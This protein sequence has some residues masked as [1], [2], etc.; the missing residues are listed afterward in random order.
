MK[1]NLAK[2]ELWSSGAPRFNCP[3]VVGLGVGCASFIPLSVCGERPIRI[4]A[5][6]VPDGLELDEV[7][8]VFKGSVRT[9]L[10]Q[11]VRVKA[12]N[13]HGVDE[14]V[15]LM[16][17]T[18]GLLLTPPLGW[19]PWNLWMEN[20]DESK[21]KLAASTIVDT[22]LAAYGYNYINIDDGW[23]GER[24]GPYNAIQGNEN[25][26]DMGDLVSYIH[27]LGLRAGIYST[28]WVVSYAGFPGGSEASSP[29]SSGFRESG[30][31]VGM[32][33]F[34]EEDARQWAEWGID[35]MKY[36][37]YPTDIASVR[38][39]ADALASC[40]RD[41]AL[42][43]SN[44]TPFSLVG[45]ISGI[46]NMWRTTGDIRDRFDCL[47]HIIEQQDK[48]TG[49]AKPG[50]WNDP[51]MM[52]IGNLSSDERFSGGNL[53]EDE[54][55]MQMTIWILLAAPLI[56][57]CDLGTLGDFHFRLLCNEEALKIH[58]DRNGQQGYRLRGSYTFSREVQS[59]KDI[60]E[61]FE[62]LNVNE[63]HVYVR[64]L[65]DGSVAI[66]LINRGNE[67]C[68]ITLYWHELKIDGKRRIR[69]VWARNDLGSF[70]GS[71]S[72][73][74]PAHGAQLLRMYI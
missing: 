45:E 33:T 35:F 49:Y 50:H 5:E 36:D 54:Q 13:K 4:I 63:G 52:I 18:R 66:G 9:P 60:G 55:I 43:L 23:Q 69:D 51:D 64:E 58:R 10:R 21:I 24:S 15:M 57:G 25:F 14:I 12:S 71:F 22:G 40:G 11:E 6:G 32:P 41:I 1:T 48:W 42:S 2:V 56:L 30:H 26:P 28:P 29:V 65:S 34:E 47:L 20:I 74:V 7:A 39:I 59:P 53:S 19:N 62:Y 70:D 73:G 8:Y 44:S 61:V 68:V 46:A 31:Y 16:D 27:T 72:I 17:S 37:W 38:R 67:G 3:E